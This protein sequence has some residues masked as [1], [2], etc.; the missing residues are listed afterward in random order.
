[1]NALTSGTI[2]DRN[3]QLVANPLYQDLNPND[4]NTTIRDPGL[5]MLGGIVGVPWQDIARDPSNLGAGFKSPDELLASG[6]WDAILGD[7]ESY[8]P[9]SNP[10]MVESTAPRGTALDRSIPDNDDVQYACTFPLLMPRD[11]SNLL[12]RNTHQVPAINRAHVEPAHVV[13]VAE[14]QHLG[15]RWSDLIADCGERE[16]G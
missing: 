14:R 6:T 9:P 2:Q 8:V 13:L 15:K 5:V 4:A 3:G 11:C 16:A 1:M 12:E 7:P 10:L